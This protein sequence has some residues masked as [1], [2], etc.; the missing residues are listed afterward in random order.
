VKVSEIEPVLDRYYGMEKKE[1][2][3]LVEANGGSIEKIFAVMKR[4]AK[5][6]DYV[7]EDLI[8]VDDIEDMNELSHEAAE[9]DRQKLLAKL[10]QQEK[11]KAKGKAKGKGK[12]Q[13]KG[14]GEGKR[15]RK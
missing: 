7:L 3:E 1:V 2:Q 14:E 15:G 9:A 13:G 5:R 10:N 11:G 4:K 6:D 8:E 12:G